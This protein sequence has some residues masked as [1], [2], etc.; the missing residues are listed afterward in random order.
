MLNEGFT[1]GPGLPLQVTMAEAMDQN[2]RLI[3]PRGMDWGIACTPP[4]GTLSEIILGGPG[5]MTGIPI[6][7][8]K[9]PLQ[10]G[11]SLSKLF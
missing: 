3:E 7:D 5:S 4:R 2:L 1:A 11:V 9:Y 8:E 10:V 6:L